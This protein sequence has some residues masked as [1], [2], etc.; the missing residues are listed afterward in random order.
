[1]RSRQSPGIHLLLCSLTRLILRNTL[2]ILRRSYEIGAQIIKAKKNDPNAAV[3]TL[4]YKAFQSCPLAAAMYKDDQPDAQPKPSNKPMP[5]M[6]PIE[7]FFH[8]VDTAVKKCYVDAKMNE[9]QRQV[10]EREMFLR[11]DIPDFLF[12]AAIFMLKRAQ[13]LKKVPGVSELIL[14]GHDVSWLGITDELIGGNLTTMK[15]GM[16]IDV[17][18]KSILGQSKN[19]K[20]CPRC[21]SVTEDFADAQQAGLPQWFVKSMRSC[22]CGDWWAVQQED[23]KGNHTRAH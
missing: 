4:Y 13:E 14:W 6:R 23:T 16:R 15:N 17:M 20:T 8:D 18:R 10:S 9:R 1:V 19:V 2:R 11:C 5:P 3:W 21:K 12:P 7:S 22:I